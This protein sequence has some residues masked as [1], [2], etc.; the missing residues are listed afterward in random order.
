MPARLYP[1]GVGLALVASIGLSVGAVWLA[2]SERG[3]ANILLGTAGF[4]LAVFS[5]HFLAMAG[6]NF[7]PDGTAP[8]SGPLM[9]NESLAML[10]TLSAFVISAAFLLTGVTFARIEDS[11]AEL[12]PSPHLWR[13]PRRRPIPRPPRR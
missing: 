13:P 5:V 6:T 2:Y 8:A 3:R 9:G 4:G 12:A 1:A 7:L 10:V 11:R